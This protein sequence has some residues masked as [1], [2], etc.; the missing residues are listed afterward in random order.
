M[1]AYAL[2]I[3]IGAFLLFQVQPMFA[4]YILPWFGG[5]PG[6]W[7]TCMLFFQVMLV[8]GYAYA[9]FLTKYAAPR[10]QAITHLT[11][12][13]AALL[14]L[15]ITPHESWKPHGDGN[16]TLQILALL[17]ANIGVPY[18]VL[19]STGPLIQ[20]WFCQIHPQQSPYRLYALSNLG[21]LLALISYPLFFETQ[22]TRQ[23][24][25]FF[26]SGGLVLY[27]F[28]CCLCGI[29]V[30]KN[31]LQN[32]NIINY[33]LANADARLEP[34]ETTTGQVI[35]VPATDRLLWLLFSA[36]AS[37]LLLATTNKACQDVAVIPFLWVMPLALYLLSFIICFGYPKLYARFPFSLALVVALGGI[38]WT[39]FQGYN[40]PVWKQVAI[41]F[42]GFFVCTM[43]CQGELFR[44]RP[45]ARHLTSFYLMIAIGGALGGAMVALIAPWIFKGYFELQVGIFCCALLFLIACWRDRSSSEVDQ[46]RR[47]AKTLPLVGIVGLDRL[48]VWLRSEYNDDYGTFLVSLRI[49]AWVFFLMLVFFPMRSS[50]TAK[51]VCTPPKLSKVL[52][53]PWLQKE[54]LVSSRC[55]QT[56]ACVWLMVGVSSLAA[57]LWLQRER[58]GDRTISVSRN[59]YGVLRV[60]DHTNNETGEHILWLRH[61]HISHGCQFSA[62]AK[63]N[64]PTLY[65]SEKSGIGL[66]TRALSTANRRI[67]I[68]GLGAGTLAA[69]GQPGDSLSFYE[70]NP[71]VCHLATTSFTYLAK[72]Q[73]KTDLILGDAR[74]SLESEPP[75]KFDLLALDAFSSDA[76]PVHLLTKEAFELYC[77]HLKTNGVIAVHISS[78]CLNLEP[79]LVNAAQFFGF[80]IVVI[81]QTP[82]GDQWWNSRSIWALLSRNHEILNSP[83]ILSAS[84][85]AMVGTSKIPLWTDDFSSLYQVLR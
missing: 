79:V 39:I 12:I 45:N 82:A 51:E 15:P 6:V 21:S 62:P 33:N 63:A 58:F 25:M 5:G 7:T 18:F 80:Q 56:A 61:G 47:M 24:Q 35:L 59:F 1:P 3:F 65:Y 2:T 38:C 60:L 69:Y 49:M 53:R 64:L 43:V 27:A 73:G 83:D 57:T 81:D 68:V 28:F 26:W 84:R 30:W 13:G 44:L 32:N 42:G 40:W 9:H 76:I 48:L 74:I 4:K 75:Q 31:P 67:G 70:I 20:Q 22:F 29:G 71:E 36:C 14:L 54:G 11:L 8:G 78:N 77:R 19:S 41:Y 17:T 34:E 50:S 72:C 16:P 66:A 23:M 10:L 37:G 85:P 52:C 55:W 46:W